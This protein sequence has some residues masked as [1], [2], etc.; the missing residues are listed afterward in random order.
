M[1]KKALLI[2]SMIVLIF[3]SSCSNNSYKAHYLVSGS[4]GEVYLIKDDLIARI[5]V[6]SKDLEEYAAYKGL[7]LLSALEDLFDKKG[8]SKAVISQKSGE[9]RDEMFSL[10]ANVTEKE[11]GYYAYFFY[12]KDLRK[13]EFLSNITKLSDE[14]DDE[15]IIKEVNKNTRFE[16]Y[17]VSPITNTASTW[18]EKRE[19]IN[20]WVSQIMR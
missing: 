14:F 19:F 1:T 12:A 8:D 17:S 5:L 2:V 13:T 15:K 7:D 9:E 20:L 11:N 18:E 10:L 4:E 3:L 6:P 16:Y